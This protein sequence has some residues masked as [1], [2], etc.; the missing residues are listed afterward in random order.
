MDMAGLYL[1][2]C[3]S[4]GS[5]SLRL[6]SPF[7]LHHRN[8][9]QSPHTCSFGRIWVQTVIWERK[10]V[11]G[12]LWEKAP[13]AT[14]RLS[15]ANPA[16]LQ[17]GKGHLQRDPGNLPLYVP[18]LPHSPPLPLSVAKSLCFSHLTHS[19]KIQFCLLR[20]EV[21][22]LGW[23]QAGRCWLNP[24]DTSVIS[25]EPLQNKCN[26]LAPAIHQDATYLC[27]YAFSRCCIPCTHWLRLC[28]SALQLESQQSSPV[29]QTWL[30]HCMHAKG[31][32]WLN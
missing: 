24:R 30:F 21:L 7:S 13:S 25:L 2:S 4:R 32:L 18:Y 10:Q 3:I 28:W 9:D 19:G 17:I 27:S 22:S 11:M 1:A 15:T 12:A 26:R 23:S 20:W 14:A 31:G 5:I 6:C 16:T 8:Q 29:E